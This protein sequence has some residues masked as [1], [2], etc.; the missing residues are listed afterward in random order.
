MLAAMDSDDEPQSHASSSRVRRALALGALSTVALATAALIY[1][2]PTWNLGKTGAPTV[3]SVAGSRHLAAVDFVSPAAGWVVL[4][5]QS[6]DFVVLHTS[7]AGV[8]WHRQL[9]GSAEVVG[10][11]MRF[12]DVSNG[13]VVVLGTQAS[14]YRTID[15]GATWRRQPLT[16]AGRYVLSAD[17]VDSAHGWLLTQAS[18]EGEALLRTDDGGVTWS[19]LGNPVAYSDWAY[20]VAFTSV[21]DGWL[22]TRS[23]APYAYQTHDAGRSWGRIAFPPPPGGWLA[24]TDGSVP[25]LTYLVEPHPTIGSGIVATLTVEGSPRNNQTSDGPV[26]ADSPVRNVRTFDG[27]GSM[28]SVY[29]DVSPYTFSFSSTSSRAVGTQVANQ[30]QLSSVDGG[31]SW[32]AI[33]M[34]SVFGAVGCFDA[35]NWWWIG[36]GVQSKT[37]DAGS[38]WS[39]IHSLQVPAPLPDSFQIIDGTHVL[40]GAMVGAAPLVEGTDDGGVSWRTILLPATP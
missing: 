38:T 10:E 36:P 19:G 18:T 7:D 29:A 9:A 35:L 22:Y 23:N 27:G 39:P 4:E 17:F 32:K 6:N 16:P 2:H 34:P 26:L 13:V 40:F 8:T 33:S 1:L 30:F 24:S 31:H 20:R 3:A 12:F 11:Y 37:S 28:T 15:G 14:L 5:R 25:T 21:N